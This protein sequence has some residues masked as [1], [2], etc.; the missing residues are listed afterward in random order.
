MTPLPIPTSEAW[1]HTLGAPQPGWL[2]KDDAQTTD[3][4]PATGPHWRESA[5]EGGAVRYHCT[6]WLILADSGQCCPG[7][8]EQGGRGGGSDPWGVWKES[9]NLI[10]VSPGL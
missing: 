5:A 8:A 2:G 7:Q 9:K 1:Q 10:N 3:P 6:A 4:T